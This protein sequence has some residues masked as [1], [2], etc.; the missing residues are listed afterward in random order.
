MLKVKVISQAPILVAGHW[1]L[2]EHIHEINESQYDATLQTYPNSLQV[3]GQP[4]ALREV[5]ASES[6]ELPV[7]KKR[8]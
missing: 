8:G 3:I 7:K 4:V 6:A 2:P 1:W 5:V